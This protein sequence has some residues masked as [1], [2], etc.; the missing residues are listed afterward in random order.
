MKY[1]CLQMSAGLQRCADDVAAAAQQIAR[2]EQIDAVR[3]ELVAKSGGDAEA[4]FEAERARVGDE[5]RAE[6]EAQLAAAAAEAEAAAAAAEVGGQA[7]LGGTMW[8]GM[9]LATSNDGFSH[10]RCQGSGKHLSDGQQLLLP[11]RW[12]NAR[13]F[14]KHNMAAQASSSPCTPVC[15]VCMQANG[16]EPPASEEP[17]IDVETQLEAAMAA[18]QHPTAAEVT[19][20]DVLSALLEQGVVSKEVIVHGL[21]V[22]MLGDEAYTKQE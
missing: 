14:L 18:V 7:V 13:C 10:V 5:K 17:Q 9:C 2:Q 8:Q 15:T 12:S 6:L 4:A 21:A 16:E 3:A 19:D 22:H 11:Q 20:G 1:L